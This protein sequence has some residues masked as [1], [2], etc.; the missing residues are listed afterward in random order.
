M[1]HVRLKRCW[2]LRRLINWL[3][4]LLRPANGHRRDEGET[5]A[6]DNL[7]KTDAG[8]TGGKPSAEQIQVL[9]HR[10]HG[11]DLQVIFPSLPPEKLLALAKLKEVR[12]IEEQPEVNLDSAATPQRRTPPG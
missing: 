10:A 2:W 3:K 5:R 12:W 6:A 11:G 9:D 4:A 1:P 8:H 7:S